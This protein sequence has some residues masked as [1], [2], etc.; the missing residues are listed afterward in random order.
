MNS[1][2][3]RITSDGAGYHKPST[4]SVTLDEARAAS[5]LKLLDVLDES[6]DVQNIYANFDIPD[7]V[8]Q[9]LSA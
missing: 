9:K 4:T 8:M 7:A 1:R 6:D 3:C 5:V 2:F